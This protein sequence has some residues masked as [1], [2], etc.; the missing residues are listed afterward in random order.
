MNWKL[1]AIIVDKHGSQ[2]RAAVRY[3]VSP[4]EITFMLH[5]YRGPSAK[6]EHALRKDFG[7][8]VIN[9]LLAPH[10][11]DSEVDVQG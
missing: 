6:L 11:E 1:K 3:G 2:M 9:P 7:D 5:G 4:S 10:P 8:D